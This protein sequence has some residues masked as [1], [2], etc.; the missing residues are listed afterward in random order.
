MEPDAAIYMVLYNYTKALSVALG[1][2][3]PLTR[4]HSERVLGLAEEIALHCGLP[5]Q[6]LGI[7]R[8][9]AAFHDVGKIGIPDAILLKA[10]SFDETERKTMREHCAIGERIMKSTEL[11][12]CEQAAHVIRHHH[13][14]Y[15]GRGYPDGL[16]GENI[17]I[18]SRIISIADSYDAMAVTRPY[19]RAKKHSEVMEILREEAGHKHD[20]QLMRV[21]CEI[22]E[23]S[24]FKAEI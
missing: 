13:E 5:D 23:H 6:E 2:R 10:S 17:P 11:D 18:C 12:G 14:Y 7:L 4:L 24:G 8:I 20:P 9:G 3:D 1:Y 22:I 15:A 16:A 19:H 21:F